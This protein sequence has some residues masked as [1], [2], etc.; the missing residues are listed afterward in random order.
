MMA[1]LNICVYTRGGMNMKKILM[2]C[3]LSSVLFSG[4]LLAV[5]ADE[6]TLPESGALVYLAYGQGN[7][8][9]RAGIAS[10]N[11]ISTGKHT[12]GS[13]TGF[14]VYVRNSSGTTM[15]S[16]SSTTNQKIE[17]TW[18]SSGKVQHSHTAISSRYQ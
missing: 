8:A 3:A 7:A 5:Y 1:N 16:D 14:A 12:G 11:Y 6:K 17:A 13:G 10:Y 9:D 2:L 4:T 15:S 18:Y